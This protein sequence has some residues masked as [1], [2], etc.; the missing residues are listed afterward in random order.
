MA[1]LK[2]KLRT[3]RV[4]VVQLQVAKQTC[5]LVFEFRNQYFLLI[6]LVLHLVD[7]LE[8]VKEPADKVLGH[9]VIL[10]ELRDVRRCCKRLSR[11]VILFPFSVDLVRRRLVSFKL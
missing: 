3:N 1:L 4:L 10:C 8:F 2:Y 11:F 9:I 6:E 7:W 5:E